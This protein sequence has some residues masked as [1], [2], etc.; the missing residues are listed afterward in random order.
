M[1]QKLTQKEVK[2]LLGSKVGRRRKAIFFGKEIESLKKGEGLLVTHKEWKDTTKLK[3][4]PSTYYYNKYNKDSKN[5]I[6]SIASVV[7]G[8]LLTKMV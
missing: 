5:K 2:D 3:T 4:K 1:P 8:Y 6:L 7:N